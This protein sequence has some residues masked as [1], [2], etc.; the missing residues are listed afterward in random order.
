MAA[1][2]NPQVAEGLLPVELSKLATCLNLARMVTHA[3][4]VLRTAEEEA[5]ILYDTGRNVVHAPEGYAFRILPDSHKPFIVGDYRQVNVK[6]TSDSLYVDTRP[7]GEIINCQVQDVHE[8]YYAARLEVGIVKWGED[9]LLAVS[10][11]SKSCCVVPDPPNKLVTLRD[12]L[13]TNV[14]LVQFQ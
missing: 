3:E 8:S 11:D 14:E 5:L 12:T 9:V 2:T 6:R 1:E 13:A 10:Q 4:A 7:V